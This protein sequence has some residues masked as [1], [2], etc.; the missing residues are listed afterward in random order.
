MLTH[1]TAQHAVSDFC[2]LY[3]THAAFSANVA[4]LTAQNSFLLGL[5]PQLPSLTVGL[6]IW[7]LDW[8]MSLILATSTSGLRPSC[9]FICIH[10]DTA[11]CLFVNPHK[12][13]PQTI[14]C[15]PKMLK[16]RILL[17]LTA[18]HNTCRDHTHTS[19][20]ICMN[21]HSCA[22]SCISLVNPY[23]SILPL[24]LDK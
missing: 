20:Y 18:I 3:W 17:I 19:I 9:R 23:C 15:C 8:P 2:H 5:S 21:T 13:I 24:G 14:W 7:V 1:L 10:V 4:I 12:E 11:L 22:T 16:I 6:W